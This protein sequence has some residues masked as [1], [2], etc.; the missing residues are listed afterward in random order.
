MQ[1]L[2]FVF[3]LGGIISPI[4][5]APFLY[6]LDTTNQ[7]VP[8][9][10]QLNNN[11]MMNSTGYSY[12]NATNSIGKHQF[13]ELANMSTVFSNEPMFNPV[14][15]GESQVYKAYMVTAFM[16]FSSS[17]PFLVLYLQRNESKCPTSKTQTDE[18]PKENIS[19]RLKISVLVILSLIIAAYTAMEDTYA[20]FLMTFTVKHLNWTKPQGSFATSVFWTSFAVG[21]FSGIFIVNF[22]RQARLLRVYSLMIIT[23]FICLVATSFY[24]IGEGVWIASVI[25]GFAM[26]I[27]FPIF[28]S[29]TEERFF[30]VDGKITALIMTTAMIG[31]IINP[32]ILSRVMD[33]KPIWFGYLLLIE[34]ILL[35]LFFTIGVYIAKLIK[36]SR[37]ENRMENDGVE[38]TLSPTVQ[39][40]EL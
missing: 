24:H 20:G 26:S 2:H 14:D 37:I 6:K 23:S 11:S 13:D 29:W 3:A 12:V 22:F 25:T 7:T 10:I 5:S 33:T 30:H 40:S 34:S 27:F 4:I 31:V 32:I 18:H 15:D 16:C 36:K 35:F 39:N 17:I 38:E 9:L 28:F 8:P 1:I 19:I 21:R